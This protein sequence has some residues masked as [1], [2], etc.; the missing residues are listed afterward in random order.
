MRVD[1]PG[2]CG[3]LGAGSTLDVIRN[4]GHLN[5]QGNLVG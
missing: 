3:Q 1:S 5:N 4:S 2:H